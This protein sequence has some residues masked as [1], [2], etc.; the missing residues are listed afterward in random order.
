MFEYFSSVP[1]VLPLSLIAFFIPLWLL[2][3]F[4][5]IPFEWVIAVGYSAV[6]FLASFLKISTLI[7]SVK[8]NAINAI[9][10][11]VFYY[12]LPTDFLALLTNFV[13]NFYVLYSIYMDEAI[14]SL[15]PQ[16][17]AANPA[18]ANPTEA[19]QST[20]ASPE[21]TR[22]PEEN[23]SVTQ[24]EPPAEKQ[25]PIP[26][27]PPQQRPRPSYTY[28]L[29]FLLFIWVD[30]YGRVRPTSYPYLAAFTLAVCVQGFLVAEIQ[31]KVDKIWL[32]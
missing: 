13:L 23:V 29:T 9:L 22:N 28:F 14:S 1:S 21:E 15:S 20:P 7:N 10:A 2:D 5:A 30:I 4:F 25:V 32:D 17:N 6:L 16:E 11:A 12:V 3:Y 26:K 8:V 31:A 24:Q 18:G 27:R 19:P